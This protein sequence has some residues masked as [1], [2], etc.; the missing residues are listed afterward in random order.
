MTR[1]NNVNDN[2]RVRTDW[3][4]AY[5]VDREM[6]VDL[7]VDPDERVGVAVDLVERH[8]WVPSRA[9]ARIGVNL[10]RLKA[11]LSEVSS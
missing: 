5:R 1:K 9:A 8:A 6:A 4:I 3:A 10:E 7:P 2:R 11:R